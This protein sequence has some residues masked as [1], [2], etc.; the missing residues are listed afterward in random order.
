MFDR[1]TGSPISYPCWF[2]GASKVG[3]ISTLGAHVGIGRLIVALLHVVALLL[4]ISLLVCHILLSVHIPARIIPRLSTHLRGINNHW[5]HRLCQHDI[6]TSPPAQ[7][8]EDDKEDDG[9]DDGADGIVDPGV[10]V[11]EVVAVVYNEMI[12][13]VAGGTVVVKVTAVVVAVACT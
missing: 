6:G 4:I 10:V 8:T 5:V 2:G 13:T 11:V 7:E 1:N 9:K 12:G 3:Y